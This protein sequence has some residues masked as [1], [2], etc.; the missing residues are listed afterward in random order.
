MRKGLEYKILPCFIV[1][2]PCL[3]RKESD[4][5]DKRVV[6]FGKC[7]V[8]QPASRSVYNRANSNGNRKSIRR[9]R[10]DSVGVW[11]WAMWLWTYSSR[12]GAVVLRDSGSRRSERD[13]AVGRR[14]RRCTSGLAPHPPAGPEGAS[15]A[16]FVMW[17]TTDV[18]L[19]LFYHRTRRIN[20]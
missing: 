9:R 7:H 1:V 11:L 17:L 12:V 20:S 15:Y 16:C 13:V 6:E 4:S 2:F 3:G 19:L 10:C 5:H 18:S 8:V 14:H